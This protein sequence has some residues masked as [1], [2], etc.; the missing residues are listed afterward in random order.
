MHGLR[1][2]LGRRLLPHALT[3]RALCDGAA[4]AR[5]ACYRSAMRVEHGSTFLRLPSLS[6]AV[7][8]LVCLLALS[9]CA[10]GKGTP[11]GG[12]RDGSVLTDGQVLPDG[13]GPRPRCGT[14]GGGCCTGR[15]CEL[16]LSCG[17]GDQCCAI[18]GG[19]RCTAAS[20]CCVGYACTGGECVAPAGS[21]CHGSSD[22]AHGLVCDA[23]RCVSPPTDPGTGMPAC[24]SV[25]GTCC[26]GFTCSAG[27]VCSTGTCASCGGTGQPCCDGATGCTGSL[28]CMG[29]SCVAPT[30]CGDDG[31][32]CCA[33]GATCSGGLDCTGGTC[34]SVATA[35]G[36]GEPCRPR[37]VC[38][39][40]FV[41]DPMMRQC[42]TVPDTCGTDGQMCCP[43]ATA[44][45]CS[46]ALSCESGACS[47]CKGP[48]I[49]CLLGGLPG[50]ECCAGAVCRPAPFIPR[51]CQGEG[52]PCTNS[53]DCCGFM[54]CTDG[55]CTA[56]TE[57]TFCIDSS[58]CADGLICD[59]FQCTPGMSMCVDPGTA[60]GAM[61]AAA[62]CGGLSCREITQGTDPLCCAEKEG[63]CQVATDCCGKMLCTDGAC[64]CQTEIQTCT[65]DGDC[66]DGLICVVG[67]CTADNGCQ[68]ERTDCMTDSQCCGLLVCGLQEDGNRT[69]CATDS[70][71]CVTTEDC[72]GLMQCVE[73][74]CSCRMS[75]DPCAGDRD[76]CG[77]STCDKTSGS[78]TGTCS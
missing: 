34:G 66:C 37:N 43:P 40:G 9:A 6:F 74:S 35:G 23:G 78:L 60:C 38:D 58:E 75:G 59:S 5:A 47:T 30:A 73:N 26:A 21:G 18:P 69:C 29:G 33:P 28:A 2:H 51:C 68:R 12:R 13:S 32:P 53:L 70:D 64:A 11:D 50:Q 19:A 31:Q 4:I 62:C 55:M 54:S 48:S 8:P 10:T 22:C 1:A 65:E 16:G 39:E 76:C 67:S 77:A 71:P 52:N 42:V 44:G 72:C 14:V 57:G 56:S 49:S 36:M 41:C 63:S 61:G 25:G 3:T 46:G 27:S 17:R 15:T 7:L 24:G 45:T 20:D